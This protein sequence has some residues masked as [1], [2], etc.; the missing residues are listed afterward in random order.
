MTSGEIGQV[1]KVSFM[2]FSLL[3][4]FNVTHW[5]DADGLPQLLCTFQVLI[6]LHT[7]KIKKIIGYY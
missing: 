1:F 4:A 7:T 5:K 2:T 6:F 3:A